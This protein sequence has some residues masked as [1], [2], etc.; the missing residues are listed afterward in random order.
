MRPA[1]RISQAIIAIEIAMYRAASVL[2]G[3]IERS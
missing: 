1:I 3:I 2:C